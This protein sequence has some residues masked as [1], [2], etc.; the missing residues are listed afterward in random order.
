MDGDGGR[1]T[2]SQ[3]ATRWGCSLATVRRAEKQGKIHPEIGA[4]GVHRFDPAEIAN[5][6]PA[7]GGRRRATEVAGDP[8][9]DGD[10]AAEVFAAFDQGVGPAEVVRDRRLPPATVKALHA[11]WRDL[12]G[13]ALEPTPA[14]RLAQLEA[15]MVELARD[16]EGLQMP[17]LSACECGTRHRR[18]ENLACPTCG[19]RAER[20]A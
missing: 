19:K 8:L 4:D 6:S 20:W 5:A 14:A 10:L 12:H 15:A 9:A 16:L 1:L 2:R 18:I 11:T 7:R 3:V 13:L 17:P